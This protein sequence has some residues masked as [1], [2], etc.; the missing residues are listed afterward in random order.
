VLSDPFDGYFDGAG[1]VDPGTLGSRCRPAIGL[2][3]ILM[4]TNRL[5]A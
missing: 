4:L 2:L 3:V 5:R 1:Y